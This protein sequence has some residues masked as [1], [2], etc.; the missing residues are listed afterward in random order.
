MYKLESDEF[1]KLSLEIMSVLRESNTSPDVHLT[2]LFMGIVSAF[3]VGGVEKE[4]F[5]KTCEYAWDEWE[6]Q[7]ENPS[8]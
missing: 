2:V 7:N 8:S 6:N 5:L 3:K 4:Q 1:V